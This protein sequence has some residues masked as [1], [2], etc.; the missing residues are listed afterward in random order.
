M[1]IDA[2]QFRSAMGSLATGV[3]VI[4][5]AGTEG[6]GAGMTATAVSSL[7]LDPPLLLACIGHEASL[8]DAIVRA[9]HFGVVMLA[10]SQGGLAEYFASRGRQ[11][12]PAGALR[13]PAGLPVVPG[14]IATID[15]RRTAVL[16]GGDHSVIVGRLEWADVREGAPLLHWRGRYTRLAP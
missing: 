6:R 9:T 7:S 4:T 3:T 11:A 10:E 5:I 12:F 1:P 2:A 16:E 14:A 15:C 13:T 8:H